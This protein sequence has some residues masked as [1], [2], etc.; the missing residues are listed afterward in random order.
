MT[1]NIE[2]EIL[3][4]LRSI[5]NNSELQNKSLADMSDG[6]IRILERQD[7]VTRSVDT[8]PVTSPTEKGALGV[9]VGLSGILV[10]MITSVALSGS[11]AIESLA[12]S[13]DVHRDA[14]T[15]EIARERD[16]R[17]TADVAINEASKDRHEAAKAFSVSRHT[18]ALRSSD[19]RYS[20]LADRISLERA[21]T[22]EQ[23]NRLDRLTDDM[24]AEKR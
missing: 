2:T 3:A 20:S 9:V 22:Q 7:K 15:A 8:I 16:D 4:A 1:D 21:E 6:I 17:I 12:H 11:N 23:L 14:M 24:R 18:A 10:V 5:N 19:Q 13:T